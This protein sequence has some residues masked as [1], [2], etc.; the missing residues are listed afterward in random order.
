MQKEVKQ[1]IVAA[2]VVIC[3]SKALILRRSQKEDAYPGKW[4]LPS[5]K[6]EPLE[7]TKQAVIREIKEETGLKV[8]IICLISIF[9]YVIGKQNE[10]RDTVQ[11]NFLVQ[12][13]KTAKVILS[14][15]HRQFAWVTEKDLRKYD[16]TRET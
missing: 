11:I 6:K 15:E 1:K 4:E 13:K 14:D 9:D 5:G 3:G 2:G 16:M 12:A 10:V 7:Q 8:K